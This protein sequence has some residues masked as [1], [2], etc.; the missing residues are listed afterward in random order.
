M[1]VPIPGSDPEPQTV[2]RTGRGPV[3]TTAIRQETPAAKPAYRPAFVPPASTVPQP[4][5]PAPQADVSGI[6][7][8]SAVKHKAFGN[9]IVQNI[10]KGLITVSFDGLE[11]R[12]QFP[13]AF[14]QGFLRKA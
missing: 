6:A 9:G 5:T 4:Q 10:D 14:Q 8:G 1:T 2:R 12:F 11:K 13:G 3:V 7:A